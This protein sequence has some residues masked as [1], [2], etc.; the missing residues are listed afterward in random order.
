MP[1]N[2]DLQEKFTKQIQENFEYDI[3]HRLALVADV[4]H[5]NPKEDFS[6][7]LQKRG[8]VP[9]MVEVYFDNVWVMD[10][11]TNQV[12]EVVFAKFWSRLLY[13]YETKKID[14]IDQNQVIEEEIKKIPEASTKNPPKSEEE[15]IAQ[16]V[17]DSIQEEK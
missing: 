16:S 8:D 6:V 12:P 1:L 9:N 13:L 3:S 11:N 2:R 17:I 10:F 14:L 15:A 5:Y 7:W 4:H